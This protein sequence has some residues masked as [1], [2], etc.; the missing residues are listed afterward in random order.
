MSDSDQIS[1]YYN[2]SA[3]QV[4]EAL[5]V[6]QEQ[7]LADQDAD[8]RSQ[9]HGPNKLREAKRHGAWE[10][11]IEQFKSMVIIVLVIAGTVA[12]AFQ[13][14]AE[15]A[16]IAAVLL[17]NAA[18][19]FVTEWKAVRSMEALREMSDDNVRVRRNGEDL[20]IYSEKLVAGD[21]IVVDAG[22]VAPAESNAERYDN[23]RFF[24][25]MAR[26]CNDQHRFFLD[27]PMG[28]CT[29]ILDQQSDPGAGDASPHAA[30]HGDIRSEK[31]RPGSLFRLYFQLLQF[32]RPG[33]HPQPFPKRC[34]PGAGPGLYAGLHQPGH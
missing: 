6:E 25:T 16:A 7:G 20:E 1:S 27:G 22:D 24:S 15:G 11:L 9:R 17:V 13:H 4:L 18:L 30:D 29:G 14:W 5:A 19:G 23:E 12:L 8:G 3:A 34:R 2:R 31:R 32:C 26:G 21:I 28:I 33:H 10:I